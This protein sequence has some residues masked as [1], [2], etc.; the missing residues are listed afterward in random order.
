MPSISKISCIIIEDE[1]PAADLMRMHIS[2]M[3][4]L[5]LRGTFHLATKAMEFLNSQKIDLIFSDINLPGISGISLIRSLTQ[6]PAVI[7][8][9][10]HPQYAVEGFEVEAIDYL[11]K[12]ISF[13]R[14]LRAMNRYYKSKMLLPGTMPPTSMP[15]NEPFIFIKCDKKMVKL[16]LDEINYFEAKKNYLL[17]KTI[18]GE[19]LTY[20]SISD[21]EEKLPASKFLRIH[22]SYI[23]A[24]DK[25]E[26]FTVSYVEINK[27][28]IP[29]GRHYS[30]VAGQVINNVKSI[31]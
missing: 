6:P 16:Y 23:I 24:L 15:S 5:E 14:F 31:I 7:F 12:P 27:E 21:M 3:E 26:C 30:L 25:I 9:T 11:V 28:T 1:K 13:E 17:V 10:A 20:Q 8:T 22:R 18:R 29:I 19:F 2:Q 4:Q